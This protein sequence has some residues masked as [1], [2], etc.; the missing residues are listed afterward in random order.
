MKPMKIK[1]GH[2]IV[3][4]LIQAKSTKQTYLGKI[5]GRLL[6]HKAFGAGFFFQDSWTKPF[7]PFLDSPD[8]N[9]GQTTVSKRKGGMETG[10]E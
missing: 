2:T 9:L 6:E 4:A 8:E 5:L 3:Y 10:R 1:E 7:V